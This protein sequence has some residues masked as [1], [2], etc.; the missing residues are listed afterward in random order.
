MKRFI[1]PGLLASALIMPAAAFADEATH[2]DRA[3]IHHTTHTVRHDSHPQ[4]RVVHHR[5]VHHPIH[6]KAALHQEYREV[7]HD[8]LDEHQ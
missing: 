7:H 8:R 3:T 4:K 6:H 1:L 5:V 2:H